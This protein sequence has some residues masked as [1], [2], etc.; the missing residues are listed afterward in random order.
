MSLTKV[1][2]KVLQNRS[3]NSISSLRNLEPSYDN[4]IVDV[5]SYD[6]LVPNLGGGKFYY[7]KSDTTSLDDAGYVIVNASGK[8]WKRIFE[9]LF[10]EDFGWGNP[11]SEA[12][13]VMSRAISAAAKLKCGYIYYKTPHYNQRT[14][15]IGKSGVV[16]K[17]PGAGP[18]GEIRVADGILLEAQVLTE[19]FNTMYDT[20]PGSVLNGVVRDFGL[21]DVFLNGNKNNNTIPVTSWRNGCG[22]KYYGIRPIF[23]RVRIH[24]QPGIGF[25]SAYFSTGRVF[26]SGYSFKDNLDI[27]V[28][29]QGIY[30]L[31]VNDTGYEGFV[32]E[33]PSD[34]PMDNIF[35]GWPSNSL[36]TDNYTPN[37]YSLKFNTGGIQKINVTNGG[38]GYTTASVTIN[39]AGTGATAQAIIESGI[40]TAIYVLLEGQ[41]YSTTTSTVTITGDGTGAS[42]VVIAD[43]LIDGCVIAEG[44][45]VGFIHSFN[46]A[47][48]WAVNF[49]ATANYPRFNANFIMG[50]SSLGNVRIGGHSR[51]QIAKI[52]THQA[53]W[54]N[55]S[56]IQKLNSFMINTDRGG[57]IGNWDE[58]NNMGT[59]FQQDYA[60]IGGQYNTLTG[61]IFSFN[62]S[63][64]N[65]LVLLGTNQIIDISCSGIIGSALVTLP[66]YSSCKLSVNSNLCGTTWNNKSKS[67]NPSSN[68]DI[69]CRFRPGTYETQ[70]IGLDVLNT[71]AW[72]DLKVVATSNF[73]DTSTVYGTSDVLYVTGIDNTITTN[74]QFTVNHKLIRTPSINDI[75]YQFSPNTTGIVNSFPRI[76]FTSLTSTSFVVNVIFPVSGS[77]TSTLRLEI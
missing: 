54:G 27:D 76:T 58:F 8:R 14:P 77:G 63:G 57:S 29:D 30:N 38:S 5:L 67:A 53:G 41:N 12:G 39:G 71:N 56:S 44:C 72:N 43:D 10:A 36:N 46:N 42:A 24:K 20:H 47:N 69:Q 25:L 19:N 9:L 37:S 1:K 55:A 70:F 59:L 31:Y 3:T 13:E 11:N 75:K 74:Q 35:V 50:E 60:F 33:G 17:G 64:N 48:G 52:D 73:N 18:E 28:K 22:V 66:T 2:N 51:Y 23:Q 49:R 61:K 34:I 45:E 26:P 40:I 21:I 15:I 68:I 62:N 7:D 16:I 6:I 4:E 65:G 32:F